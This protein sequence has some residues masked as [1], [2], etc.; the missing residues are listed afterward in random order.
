MWR[1][2][3][4]SWAGKKHNGKLSIKVDIIWGEKQKKNALEL[5]FGP[6]TLYGGHLTIY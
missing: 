4:G 2:A 3:E 5:E 1:W 6:K